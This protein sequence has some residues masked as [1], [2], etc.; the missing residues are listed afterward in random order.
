MSLPNI[1]LGMLDQP[2]SG[3]DL[4]REFKQSLNHFWRAEL[5]QIYPALNKLERDGLLASRSEAS[6]K[7]PARRVYRRTAKGTRQ[8]KKWLS[9]PPVVGHERLGH[10]AK[11]YF[12]DQLGDAPVSRAYFVRLKAYFEDWL[13][14]LKDV[15]TEWKAE[16]PGYPDALPDEAFYKQLTLRNG[17]IELS[18]R[19]EWASECIERIDMRSK[20]KT[21]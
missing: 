8:L 13:T 5:A 3:Y 18:A 19:I 10:L 7:G 15:E 20:S 21:A 17:L 1:L 4:A 12:F 9:G 16:D 2:A 11:I 14:E 6:E